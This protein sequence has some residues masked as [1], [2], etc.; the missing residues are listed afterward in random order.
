M[1]KLRTLFAQTHE[2]WVLKSVAARAWAPRAPPGQRPIPAIGSSDSVDFAL[3][4]TLCT[5]S[6]PP[7]PSADDGAPMVELTAVKEA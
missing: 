1:A 4:T 6:K 3:A 2:A 7:P 5:S